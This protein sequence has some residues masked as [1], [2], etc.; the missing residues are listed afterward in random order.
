MQILECTFNNT[1]PKTLEEISLFPVTRAKRKSSKVIT[2]DVHC[3]CRCPYT[4]G[5]WSSA[6][7]VESGTMHVS[8]LQNMQV[9]D[10][11]KEKWF[12]EACNDREY[13][14]YVGSL[15]YNR[16]CNVAIATV[17]SYCSY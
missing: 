8:C 3:T 11:I 7:H 13:L 1:V 10:N 14:L 12:C 17:G 9:S 15:E 5:K 4:G 2:I 16:Q 6:T